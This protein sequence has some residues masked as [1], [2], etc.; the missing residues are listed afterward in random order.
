[1]QLD[2]QTARLTACLTIERPYV[3]NT[4]VSWELDVPTDDRITR[5]N[6]AG[7]GFRRSMGFHDLGHYR[8]VEWKHDRWHDIAWMQFDPPGPAD[9]TD[10][11]GLIK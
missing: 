10:P 6:E 1:V 9:G 5:P 8:R 7:N 11:P 3:E 4:A 2:T